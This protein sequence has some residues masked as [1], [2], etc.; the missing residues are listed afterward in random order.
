MTP[1]VYLKHQSL[2]GNV[3]D[4]S[5]ADLAYKGTLACVQRM[6]KPISCVSTRFEG[7]V[8]YSLYAA[9]NIRDYDQAWVSVPLPLQRSC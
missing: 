9:P 8:D 6:M 3:G 2:R 7:S 5:N 1:R 4:S